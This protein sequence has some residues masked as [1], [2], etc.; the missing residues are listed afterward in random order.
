MKVE[1]FSAVW[2]GQFGRVV[3]TVSWKKHKE[4]NET[5]GGCEEDDREE[6]ESHG[7][8]CLKLNVA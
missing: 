8:Q 6:I 5:Y 7:F 2:T 1:A 4:H 3:W